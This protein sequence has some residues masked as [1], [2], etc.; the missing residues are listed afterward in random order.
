[1]GEGGYVWWGLDLYKPPI[2]KP[3]EVPVWSVDASGA[4]IVRAL[5]SQGTFKQ[6][7]GRGRVLSVWRED[8]HWS[9]NTT[10]KTLGV[11]LVWT[12]QRA[13]FCHPRVSKISDMSNVEL[14]SSALERL[15]ARRTFPLHRR[16]GVCRSLFG[17]VDHEELSRDVKAKL[18]EISERDRQRWNFNFEADT[19]LDGDYKWEEVP[20]EKSPA[21][22]R[23]CVQSGR[24]PA[25]PVKQRASSDC[26]LPENPIVLERLAVPEGSGTPCAAEVNQ[27]NRAQKVYS[28][29]TS[30]QLPFTGRKRSASADGNARITGTFKAPAWLHPSYPR[31]R[32]KPTRLM[33]SSN[34][35][36]F[37]F[38][39]NF[40]WNEGGLLT[41]KRMKPA[42]AISPSQ[43]SWW[44]RLPEKG[45]AEGNE[46]LSQLSTLVTVNHFLSGVVSSRT[47]S[48]SLLDWIEALRFYASN[49]G[50]K[51]V[52]RVICV[53]DGV[54]VKMQ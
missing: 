4:Y 18:R 49:R 28:G 41:K 21:F 53:G 50:F 2:R 29:R 5:P 30:R 24:T 48:C 19:P 22:Y 1:M 36:F 43:P 44:S 46:E 20:E 37:I 51:R 9:H 10:T 3:S 13:S 7:C 11:P 12:P 39:Q 8:T 45:S 34:F 38:V 35:L 27:E 16:T 33:S 40:S 23:D 31:L 15:V 25:T 6:I 32:F 14:S 52:Q 47:K 42:L 54:V 26:A 17:P